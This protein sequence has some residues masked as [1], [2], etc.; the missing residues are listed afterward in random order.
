MPCTQCALA[1]EQ[2]WRERVGVETWL[3]PDLDTGTC[4]VYAVPRPKAERYL[5][6]EEE[7]EKEEQEQEQEQEQEGRAQK[8]SDKSKKESKSKSENEK[9]KEKEKLDYKDPTRWEGWTPYP[10][11]PA[12]SC[13]CSKGGSLLDW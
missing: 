4:R 13:A 12:A 8:P 1:M 6:Y 10:P 3:E 5:E 7:V 2:I 9:G 11:T